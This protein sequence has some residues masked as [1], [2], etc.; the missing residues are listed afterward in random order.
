MTRTIKFRAWDGKHIVEPK[1]PIFD[2]ESAVYI[3]D[4]NGFEQDYGFTLMQ[5]TG[6]L[7]VHGKEIYEGHVVKWHEEIAEVR[8]GEYCFTGDEH[9]VHGN[10]FYL[11]SNPKGM[12]GVYN[13]LSAI[14]EIIGNVYENPSL[15]AGE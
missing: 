11:Y 6:L 1:V 2:G 5:F 13:Q 15:L 4:L 8:F 10:G 9:S 3:S 14:Y 7:D 12:F